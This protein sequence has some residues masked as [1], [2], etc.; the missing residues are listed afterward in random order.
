[1][2]L[3][4]VLDRVWKEALIGVQGMVSHVGDCFGEGT[5][6]WGALVPPHR[7]AQRD[8]NQSGARP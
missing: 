6:V 8:T 7:K 4:Q 1:M 2:I 5:K 3:G